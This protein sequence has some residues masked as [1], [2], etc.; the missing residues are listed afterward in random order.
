MTFVSEGAWDGLEVS[1]SLTHS[2]APVALFARGRLVRLGVDVQLRDASGEGRLLDDFTLASHWGLLGVVVVEGRW[3]SVLGL[4]FVHDLLHRDLV[5]GLGS[6][7]VFGNRD[8][9]RLL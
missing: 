7:F 3:G 1:F 2:R 9:V 6:L 5:L 4:L 8:F